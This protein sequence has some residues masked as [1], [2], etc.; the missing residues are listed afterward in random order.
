LGTRAT[1][2]EIILQVDR[3]GE[4][5]V[6]LADEIWRLAELRFDEHESAAA[7]VAALR[8]SRPPSTSVGVRRGRRFGEEVH[9]PSG[10]PAPRAPDAASAVLYGAPVPLRQ[11]NKGMVHAAKVMAATA[12]E[13][14]RDPAL[15]ARATAELPVR[16]GT[17][18]YACPISPEVIPPPLR[19]GRRVAITISSRISS[20]ETTRGASHPG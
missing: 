19:R 11:P 13:A 17:D 18:G 4:A 15:L 14:I 3:K 20:A 1:L 16:V 5:F 12:L 10:R 7:H 2:Q 9:G 6:A 8:G